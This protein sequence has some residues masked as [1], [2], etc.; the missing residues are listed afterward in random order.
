MVRGLGCLLGQVVLGGRGAPSLQEAPGAQGAPLGP[1]LLSGL[2]HLWTQGGL[3]ALVVLSA[4]GARLG[5]W[6]FS[7]AAPGEREGWRRG[8]SPRSRGEG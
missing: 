6:A 3:Q 5:P 7:V 2:G 8:R 4:L 1:S